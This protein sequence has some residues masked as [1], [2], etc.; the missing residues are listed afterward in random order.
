MAKALVI[1]ATGLIGRELIDLLILDDYF[2]EIEIWV[3]KPSY[4]MHPKISETILDFDTLKSIPKISHDV[5]FC[6]I[7]TTIKKAGSKENFRKID[8]DIVVNIAHL[9]E[10]SNVTSLIAISSL[11]ATSKTGNL[12]LKTKGEMEEAILDLVIPSISILRPSVL[13]GNRL[14]FRLGEKIAIFVLKIFGIFLSLISFCK[15]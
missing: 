3:R 13:F 11:G 8:Y 14:D 12:Y 2:S 4:Y 15:F 9:A 1:G 6:C 7:G 5:V 10:R